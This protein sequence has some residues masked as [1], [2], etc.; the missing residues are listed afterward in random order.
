MIQSSR[1][2]DSPAYATL[3]NNP[4]LKTLNVADNQ[5]QELDFTAT[6]LLMTVAVSY[7]HL[8]VYKRQV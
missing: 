2:K 1:K 5:L 7:T 6:P 4:K 8:D 3:A